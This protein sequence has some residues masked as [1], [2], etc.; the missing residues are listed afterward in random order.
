MKKI[1]SLFTQYSNLSMNKK[2]DLYVFEKISTQT[3]STPSTLPVRK[4]ILSRLYSRG[5]SSFF[6]SKSN[7]FKK[8]K[9]TLGLAMSALI[10]TGAVPVFA[11]KALPGDLLYPIKTNF[12]ERLQVFIETTPEEKAKKESIFAAKRLEEA[13][14]LL[15][16]GKLKPEIA[17]RVHQSFEFHLANVQKQLSLLEKDKDFEKMVEVGVSLQTKVAVHVAVLKDVELNTIMLSQE[18]VERVAQENNFEN[19]PEVKTISFL[20]KSVLTAIIPTII[21]TKKALLEISSSTKENSINVPEDNL[22]LYINHKEAKD[23]LL[24]LHKDIG[25]P[26]TILKTVPSPTIPT[27]ISPL[28]K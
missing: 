6:V 13:E 5:P 16:E 3:F 14:V 11:E 8:E 19:L 23:Y 12:N 24:T 15:F 18:K 28:L 10:V 7:Y 4:L 1:T 25:I 27:Y 17:I 26:A 21:V 22:K 20:E 9:L 2:E